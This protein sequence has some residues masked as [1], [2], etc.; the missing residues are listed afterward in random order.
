MIYCLQYRS[1]RKYHFNYKCSVS[2]LSATQSQSFRQTS[3]KDDRLAANGVLS[4][5]NGYFYYI[6]FVYKLQSIFSSIF[7]VQV[8]YL[9]K[10]RNLN[11]LVLRPITHC[12]KK[13]V[14]WWSFTHYKR[15]N[16]FSY[17]WH[18]NLYYKKRSYL[19]TEIVNEKS[20][21]SSW[22]YSPVWALAAAKTFFQSSLFSIRTT[23]FNVRQFLNKVI[24]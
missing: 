21:S 14:K 24:F 10:L 1:Q 16:A 20:S 9:L 17:T 22:L 15:R 3:Y 4:R 6:L 23:G 19:L 11:A 8:K 13:C 5:Y 12:S 18:K 2:F 7:T